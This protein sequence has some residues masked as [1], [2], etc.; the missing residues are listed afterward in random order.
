MKTISI[1]ECRM[2]GQQYYNDSQKITLHPDDLV[3]LGI[4]TISRCSA[5]KQTQERTRQTG[6]RI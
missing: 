4:R 1:I 3:A 2:C 6:R 5:C